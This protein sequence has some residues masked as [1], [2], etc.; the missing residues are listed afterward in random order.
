MPTFYFSKKKPPNAL[1]T[2]IRGFYS[3]YVL[4]TIAEG[5]RFLTRK[6]DLCIDVIRTF[7]VMS[8]TFSNEK[9]EPSKTTVRTSPNSITH[10]PPILADRLP[11]L[12]DENQV[13]PERSVLQIARSADKAARNVVRRIGA[14]PA[15][16][17]SYGIG[18]GI[19]LGPPSPNQRIIDRRPEPS[20]S[21]RMLPAT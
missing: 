19:W 14:I 2:Q 16:L 17:R 8:T 21:P 10:L 7:Q 1:L 15:Y 13:L 12:S 6:G 20:T 18:A 5:L 11:C 9:T 4:S 3:R